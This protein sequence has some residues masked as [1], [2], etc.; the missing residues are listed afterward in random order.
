VQAAEDAAA[1]A[2]LAKQTADYQALKAEYDT[3]KTDFDALLAR[4]D[5]GAL[6]EEEIAALPDAIV[7]FEEL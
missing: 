4:D 3:A 2:A 6:T 1:A 7:A 5:E